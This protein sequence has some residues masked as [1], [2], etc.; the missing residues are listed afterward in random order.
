MILAAKARKTLCPPTLPLLKKG[1]MILFDYRVLHR[2]RQNLSLDQNRT[3]LVMTFSKPW[4]KDAL[5][6]PRRSII[7]ECAIDND[8][9]KYVK[10]RKDVVK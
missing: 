3:M 6:Y 2:G 10:H 5:N 7:D 4:F 9:T 1:D 8:K